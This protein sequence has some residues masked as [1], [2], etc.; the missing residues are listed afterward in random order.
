MV[1]VHVLPAIGGLAISFKKFNLF[2]FHELFGAPWNGLENYRSILLDTDNPLHSG[3]WGAVSNTVVYTFW[4]VSGTLVGGL[5][6]RAAAAPQDARPARGAHADA[7]AVD[8]AE[9]RRRGAVELHV[10]ERR[11]DH[12]QGPR[13]L[14]PPAGPPADLAAGAQHDVGDRDPEHLARAA[15]RD[16]HLPRRPA[17]PARRSCTRRRPSTAP[18]RC[19]ACASSPCRCCAR[20]SACSCSSASSTRPTSSRS[21]P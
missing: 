8:R 13:R 1:L 17:G 6:D 10:A 21:R 11:G 2:T 14:H 7:R 19:G 16:P 3:F 15:A 5:A 12:Q 9:L 18:A 4:T 20:S